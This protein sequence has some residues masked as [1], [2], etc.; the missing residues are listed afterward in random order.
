MRLLQQLEHFGMLLVRDQRQTGYVACGPR[1]ITSCKLDHHLLA[2][3]ADHHGDRARCPGG[4]SR[5]FSRVRQDHIGVK[6]DEFVYE[7]GHA[8]EGTVG[9][10]QDDVDVAPVNPTQLGERVAP[11][12]AFRT[13][14][15]RSDEKHGEPRPADL[16]GGGRHSRCHYRPPDRGADEPGNDLSP[17]HSITSLALNRMEVG[18]VRPSALAALTFTA[19]SN[20]TG[21]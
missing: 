3:R 10:A 17:P 13:C 5:R 6:G 2:C 1:K 11:L 16:C 14:H 7:R 20:L 9:G 15:T 4:C 19:I 18:T 8:I 12:A 21:T